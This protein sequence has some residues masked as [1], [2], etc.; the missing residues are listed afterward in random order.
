M[1]SVLILVDT[2][3]QL[4]IYALFIFIILG[5]LVQFNVINTGNR[6]VYLVMDFLY[7]VTEPLLRPIRNVMPNLGGLDISPIILV[8]GLTFA[9]N[10]M[11]EYLG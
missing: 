5:W 8:L 4:Y 3:V 9:R 1:Q 6:F 2:V 7:R 10:L 11:W